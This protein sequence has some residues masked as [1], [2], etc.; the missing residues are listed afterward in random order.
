LGGRK[1]VKWIATKA[2]DIAKYRSHCGEPDDV[3]KSGAK[4]VQKKDC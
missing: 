3:F 2:L 4:L 1:A